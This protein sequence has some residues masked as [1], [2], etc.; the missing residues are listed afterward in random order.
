MELVDESPHG[1]AAEGYV[2]DVEVTLVDGGVPH[3]GA[4]DDVASTCASRER[5]AR[6]G[7]MLVNVGCVM[8]ERDGIAVDPDGRE[9]RCVSVMPPTHV[10]SGTWISRDGAVRQRYFDPIYR[11]W[12]WGEV[13]PI[14]ADGRVYVGTSF[15]GGCGAMMPI[16]RAVGLAWVSVPEHLARE[17]V[18][19]ARVLD[20]S[21][22]T[23]A[24]N[25]GWFSRRD[26]ARSYRI[27]RIELVHEDGSADTPDDDGNGATSETRGETEAIPGEDIEW[28]I[29]RYVICT[30]HTLCKRFD[31]GAHGQFFVSSDGQFR[32]RAGSPV[33][34]RVS[35]EHEYVIDV[36]GFGTI[37][38]ADAVFQTFLQT[39]LPTAWSGRSPEEE[40]AA[41]PSDWTTRCGAPSFGNLSFDALQTVPR[42]APRIRPAERRAF[43]IVTQ[44]G[45]TPGDV[46]RILGI[47]TNTAYCHLCR[48]ATT[49]DIEEIPR[50]FWTACIP[51]YVGK[52][53]D[54]LMRR[55]DPVLSGPLFALRD[56]VSDY[57]KGSL[58]AEVRRRWYAM[59][60]TQWQV[61]RIARVFIFRHL[62]HRTASRTAAHIEETSIGATE[63]KPTTSR[64]SDSRGQRRPRPMRGKL[65]DASRRSSDDDEMTLVVDMDGPS[66]DGKSA[67]HPTQTKPARR[68]SFGRGRRTPS[69][70]SASKKLAK[71]NRKKKK[72]TRR[73]A[74]QRAEYDD[75]TLE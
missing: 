29:L 22:G 62:L 20:T 2:E 33:R 53:L 31:P 27:G 5:Y 9:M 32:N 30:P 42:V 71:K 66:A 4:S 18:K 70:S 43:E 61:L 35:S 26:A 41:G 49:L 58:S 17:R 75:V 3:G 1:D 25:V 38:A 64:A 39:F 63:P 23:T 67:V 8:T 69:P 13:K 28:R 6:L 47:G 10:M 19:C 59:S 48:A 52:A 56:A 73:G 7:R 68:G 16:A 11:G 46:A 60:D 45:G 36:Q 72:R 37:P 65:E 14:G 57:V 15:S 51:D 21:M 24:D 55:E 34:P 74:L 54:T 44:K 50:Q 40:M 12:A